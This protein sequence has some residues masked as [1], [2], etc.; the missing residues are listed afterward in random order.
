MISLDISQTQRVTF[1]DK[2]N[3]IRYDYPPLPSLELP[4]T[5]ELKNKKKRFLSDYFYQ[6]KIND[7]RNYFIV[8][9]N[10]SVLNCFLNK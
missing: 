6:G 1:T 3:M 10:V 8:K 9:K 4:E 2:C 5:F 7:I